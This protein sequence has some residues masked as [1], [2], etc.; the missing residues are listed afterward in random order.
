MNK[1]EAKK[2]QLFCSPLSINQ[3][4]AGKRWGFF[5]SKYC[6]EGIISLI[7]IYFAP[8][9]Q[10][11]L[12]GF[13]TANCTKPSPKIYSLEING[14]WIYTLFLQDNASITTLCR[15]FLQPKQSVEKLRI[16]WLN[17]II[18]T[19]TPL[20]KETRGMSLVRL[21]TWQVEVVG[22]C[23]SSWSSQVHNLSTFSWGEAEEEG[24]KACG[25]DL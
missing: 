23:L 1:R 3:L 16:G 25:E 7:Y 2:W 11:V 6:E 18:C 5:L 4:K 9:V 10:Q 20:W 15:P 13:E 14:W 21:S 22:V 12:K 17:N 8:E 19:S 24:R